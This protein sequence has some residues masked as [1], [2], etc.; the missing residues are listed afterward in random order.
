VVRLESSSKTL[1]PGLRVGWMHGP[2]WLMDACATLKQSA[3]L[4]T[5][6]LDQLIV[7]R[8]ISDTTWFDGH[9]AELRTR[10]RARAQAF[11]EAL[12]AAFGD[13]LTTAPRRGGLFTW[14]TFAD[15][16][17]TETL[18]ARALDHG[19]AFVPGAAFTV[20]SDAHD[21]THDASMRLCHATLD[22]PTL[23]R[24]V[25][26]LAAAHAALR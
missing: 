1:A 16:T 8:L 19:V 25:V 17:D 15:G 7:E 2:R 21:P 26:R 10:Y 24:A 14:A 3:D 4:H 5:S 20:G 6:T 12:S 22:E 11:D 23:A 18:A 9:L 13:R